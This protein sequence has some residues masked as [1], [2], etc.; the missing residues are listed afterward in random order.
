MGNFSTAAAYYLLGLL[1]QQYSRE[2]S[3]T[4]LPTDGSKTSYQSMWQQ[5]G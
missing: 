2:S 5:N 3:C 1:F 4:G